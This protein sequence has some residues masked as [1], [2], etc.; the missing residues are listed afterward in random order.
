MN[1]I[2]LKGGKDVQ[3]HSDRFRLVRYAS[4]FIGFL[5]FYS[6]AALVLRFFSGLD[7][8]HLIGNLCD[9]LNLRMGVGGLLSIDRWQGMDWT[10]GQVSIFVVMAVALILGPLFCGWLCAAG[11][12]TEFVGRLVPDRWKIDVAGK[13]D[14]GAVRYGFLAGYLSLPFFGTG[15]G[16]SFCNFRVLEYIG[17]GVGSGFLPALTS[18]YIVV[19]LLWLV[20][21]GM[22]MKGGRG[23]CVFL[24]P[25]G[26]IQNAMHAIGARLPFTA[27]MR[28][29]PE[30]CRSCGNCVEVCPMRAIAPAADGDWQTSGGPGVRISLNT[31]IACAQCSAA[32]PHGALGYGFG[33]LAKPAS[34]TL[35][36]RE[37]ARS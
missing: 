31:C 25:V 21:G 22:F 35:P 26:G 23:W 24:C 27:K 29:R 15:I 33:P 30:N 5:L 14:A 16:C 9:S 37:A 10:L 12:F 11:A 13:V 8:K 7:G 18:T 6:P 1:R 4:Y 17:L 34:A 2:P 32:C 3:N 28:Y 19:T 36:A 20:A